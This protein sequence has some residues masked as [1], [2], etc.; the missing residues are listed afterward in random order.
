M[1]DGEDEEEADL[2]DKDGDKSK[3]DQMTPF[4]SPGYLELKPTV[5]MC[6]RP[7]QISRCRSRDEMVEGEEGC[8]EKSKNVTRR[9][10]L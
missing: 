5:K 9:S 6:R 4:L 3:I 10:R 7:Q 8:L 2:G 1:A